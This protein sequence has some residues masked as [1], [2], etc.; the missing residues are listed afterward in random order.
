MMKKICFLLIILLS[1]YYLEAQTLSG[2]VID[3]AT[4]K[5]IPGV[6]IYL[7]QAKLNA[8]TDSVGRYTILQVPKGTYSVQAQLLGY[9]TAT[10]QVTIIGPATLNFSLALSTSTIQEV[11]I[12]SLGN[13]TNTLRSPV[14]VA[15]VTH[16]ALLQSTSSNAVDAIALQ[17]GVSEVTTGPGVS[18][19]EINGLGYN[20]VLTLMDGE[21]QEDFQWGDE[22]GILID[23]YVIYDAEIVRGAASLQYGANAMAGVV[24]FKPEPFP[25]NGTIQGSV[26]GEYQTNNGLI[27]TSVDVGGNNKDL[28]WD[29]RA[30][31][32]EAHCYWDP[33]DGYVWGTAFTQSD[34]RGVLGLNEKWG[35]SRLSISLLQ[36]QIEIP[37]GNRD[38]AT[39]KFEFDFPQPTT[40]GSNPQLYPTRSNFLSYSP[41]IAGYQVLDHDE[42]W[43]QN[44]FNA[45]Q[46]SIKADIGYSQSH[47]EEIDSG[48]IAAENMT[49]HDIPYSIKYQIEG[50][51]SGLK[52]TG[53]VNGM[54]EFMTNASE[55][56]APYIGDFEIPNYTDFDI[57]GYA[58]LNKDY[59]NLSVSGGLRYDY[60]TMTGQ[61]MY[62]ANYNTPEQIQV[63]TG[64]AGAYTQ[65]PAFNRNFNGISGS[66]GA[67]YQL[68]GKNY[69][70]LNLAKSF[71]APAISEL[72]SNELDPAN[73]YRLGNP[74][75]KAESGY[76]VDAAFGNNGKQ[77]NFEVD[78]F[79]NY[80]NNFIFDNKIPSKL[81]GDSLQLGEPV[82]KYDANTALIAGVSA[83]L[84]IHPTNAK[85]IELDNSFTYIYSIFLN[86]GNSDST[87]YVPFTPAP[88][89]TSNV[90]FNIPT[91]HTILK[92]TYV[93]IGLAHY[94]AQNDIYSAEYNELPSYA[95]T[96]YNA[97]VG[98]NF[99]SKK[100]KRVVCSLF[101]NCT[102]LMN[103]AYFDHTSRPVYFLTY[104]GVDAI[105]VTNPT[106]G[107]YN[108][109][110]N[111]GFKLIVPFGNGTK[112]SSAPLNPDNY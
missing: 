65:F 59:K 29:L 24:S 98:T 37:D 30:S 54:Y 110:R 77:I 91:E 15:M 33:K 14:P 60:R 4:K 12:T 99:V 61:P 40:D 48:T 56:T 87:R 106:Q 64:I 35:Y 19:P 76:E 103:I 93:E 13:V 3:A 62:L 53:G 2:T 25:E 71:R 20:R 88:R 18:K 51:H 43:W 46:G 85:W 10:K 101:I 16:D 108:M 80:I 44:S 8:T 81:G 95:Y 72:T 38:S 111:V 94:W 39:G 42:L 90:K 1:G 49:V 47:R 73:I 31:S 89:L 32:E 74:N 45:G 75:L 67:S 27:G 66:I 22:H 7:P 63:P 100:T 11:V 17:P 41:N 112:T 57:G 9:A 69:V 68:P 26:L 21:R 92:S 79:C 5:T 23:P 50:D 34:I 55:P 84:N 109:G 52:F 58:I 107:I 97:G 36:R 102:N 86:Q 70:K 105:T 78:G 83:Y 6:I 104:H 96:L 82:Y 28:E